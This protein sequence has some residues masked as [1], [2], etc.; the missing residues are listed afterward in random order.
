[1]IIDHEKMKNRRLF[2]IGII[3]ITLVSIAIAL[4]T[5]RKIFNTSDLPEENFV[6]I[7]LTLSFVPDDCDTGDGI[8]N[9]Y[10]DTENITF[11]SSS[12]SGVAFKRD[13]GKTYILTAD[14]FCNST[15]AISSYPLLVESLDLEK[16]ITITD[17]RGNT[18]DSKIIYSDATSDLCILESDLPI[19]REIELS[20]SSP[21]LG[22]EIYSISAPLGIHDED[23][24]L[25]FFGKFSGC[26]SRDV[27]FYTIPAAPGSS[28][29][30]VLNQH[31][32][33]I[34]MIQMTAI[35]FNSMSMGVG[36]KT[37]KEFLENAEQ[38]T[39]IDFI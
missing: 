36:V 20:Y 24:Y 26:N 18:R 6:N 17:Y 1:M 35:G 3:L 5:S 11:M 30:L 10:C 28:G 8:Q 4:V 23:V 38:E 15:G 27:C 31:N 37:I 32:R 21:D 12:A 34:G 25:H 2:K 39:G 14:H 33:I 9:I 13:N 19:K 22:E 7:Q 29:S 16:D